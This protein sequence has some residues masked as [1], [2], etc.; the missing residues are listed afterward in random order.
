MGAMVFVELHRGFYPSTVLA[1]YISQMRMVPEVLIQTYTYTAHH[2]N[3]ALYF[4]E[5]LLFEILYI[6]KSQ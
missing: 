3:M 4:P 6:H 5:L 1:R 2:R